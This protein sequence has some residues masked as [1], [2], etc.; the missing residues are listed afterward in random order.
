MTL[1]QFNQKHKAA[2]Q[3]AMQ[4]IFGLVATMADLRTCAEKAAAPHGGLGQME[5]T[6]RKLDA[7]CACLVRLVSKLPQEMITCIYDEPT[8]QEDAA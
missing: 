5:E 2:M 3:K 4:A 8:L 7:C 1:D 6:A